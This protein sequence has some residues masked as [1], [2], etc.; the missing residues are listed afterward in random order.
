VKVPG[1]THFCD[2]EK[3]SIESLQTV[4]VVL[5]VAFLPNTVHAICINVH[6]LLK[7]DVWLLS[8]L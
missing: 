6:R 8:M 7:N 1:K 4:T 3:N 2:V 5:N